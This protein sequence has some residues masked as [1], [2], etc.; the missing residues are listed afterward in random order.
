MEIFKKY[1]MKTEQRKKYNHASVFFFNKEQFHGLEKT[2][3]GLSDE[4]DL[5]DAMAVTLIVNFRRQI[6]LHSAPDLRQNK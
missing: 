3:V 6:T 5:V 2:P 1:L 4:V